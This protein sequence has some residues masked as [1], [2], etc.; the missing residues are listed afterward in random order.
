MVAVVGQIIAGFGMGKYD[1]PVAVQRQPRQHLRKLIR[2]GRQLARP[3]RVWPDRA[4]M[5]APHLNAKRLGGGFA[6]GA[7]L[8]DAIGIE[9]DMGVIAGD[10]ICWFHQDR[11][12]TRRS[13]ANPKS[14]RRPC[15]GLQAIPGGNGDGVAGNTA[16]GI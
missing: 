6:K 7:G 8:I 9:I 1:Q 16:G 12:A 3:L 10:I 14:A 2:T 5:H 4:F 15:G 11:M 13:A